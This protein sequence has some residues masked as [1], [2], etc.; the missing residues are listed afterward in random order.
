MKDDDFWSE[1]GTVI[2][3]ARDVEFRVFMPVGLLA[4]RSAVFKDLFA[5]PH[6]TRTVSL[7]GQQRIRCPVIAFTD[8]AHDLRNI[9]RLL[10]PD[11][12]SSYFINRAPSFDELSACIRLGKKYQMTE[13]YEQALAHV[14]AC[15][16]SN[17]ESWISLPTW[18]SDGC[19]D[20]H[21]I[22]IINLARLT[23]ELSIL[24]SAFLSS[25]TCQT[26]ELCQKALRDAIEGLKEYVTVMV[27]NDP[28]AGYTDYVKDEELGMCP[29][30]LK[31]LDDLQDKEHRAL[32][33]KLPELLGIIVPGWGQ[34]ALPEVAAA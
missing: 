28:F 27:H 15:H 11:K 2:F 16:T 5:Q 24:P 6:P 8:S 19:E 9:L 13:L 26:K 1:D 23:G 25:S 14:K 22:G 34:P 4:N 29:E 21:A 17:Y 3:L 33:K 10:M 18:L 20:I 32:W 30:C 12:G 31:P 7:Y